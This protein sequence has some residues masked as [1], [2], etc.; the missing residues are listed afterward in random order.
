MYGDLVGACLFFIINIA[1]YEDISK[2]ENN[3][4]SIYI[5][6]IFVRAVFLCNDLCPFR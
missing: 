3:D 2:M 1:L 4:F 6:G 5:F